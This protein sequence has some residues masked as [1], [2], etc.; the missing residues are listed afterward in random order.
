MLRNEQLIC[1]IFEETDE[2]E[3]RNN[4]EQITKQPSSIPNKFLTVITKKNLKIEEKTKEDIVIKQEKQNTQNKNKDLTANINSV[5]C[6]NYLTN[7]KT[8]FLNDL[9]NEVSY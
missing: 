6:L 4:Y 7:A 5:F 9:I 8:N 1:N 3:N 2:A